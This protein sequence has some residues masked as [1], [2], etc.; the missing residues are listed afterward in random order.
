[1]PDLWD[2]IVVGGGTAGL[3]AAT[4]AARRGAKVLVIEAA[5]VIGGTTQISTGQLSA[6]GSRLQVNTGVTDTP[7]L[8]FDDV[9]RISK[10]TCD[11]M[12]VRLA[13]DHAAD[14]L[15]WLMDSGFTPLD[16]HPVLGK[17]HEPYSVERYCWGKDGGV[18]ILEAIQPPYEAE[19]AKGGATTML[20][21]V[22]T[23]LIEEAGAIVGVVAKGLDGIATEYR[24]RNILLTTGGY[25]SNGEMFEAINGYKQYTAEA[26]PYALGQGVTLAESAGGQMRGAEKYYCSFGSV[27]ESSAIPSKV[28]ARPNHWPEQRAPWEV[29]VN[30]H[31]ERFIAEDNPSVD[32]REHALLKQPDLRYW[33]IFD[34]HIAETA[35]VI[36]IEWTREKMMEAFANEELFYSADT[37]AEL[38]TAA[39]IDGTNLEKSIADYNAALGGD[40]PLGRQHRPAPVVKPPFYAVRAQGASITSIAGLNVDAS[41]RVLD[42]AGNPIP[43]L[44]AAGEIL[45]SGQTMG[46][47][48]VGGM[49]VTPALTFGRMLGDSMLSWTDEKAAAAE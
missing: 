11:P 39:G 42:K 4:F 9:I 47:A 18:S 14:T 43:N 13:V 21:T 44:F 20:D 36:F 49:M 15:D 38:A 25:A 7:D 23:D 30:V 35:P 27:M 17:A 16:N 22:V 24:G 26:Y 5:P 48:S 41:L 1:M 28:L 46:E 2:I 37:L 31:G 45:G 8:H 34:Q 6:A 19:V 12:L 10:N 33:I 40:D 32:V 29:Y 3:P